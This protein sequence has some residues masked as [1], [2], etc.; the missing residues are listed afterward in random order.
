MTLQELRYLVALADHGHFARAAAACHVGQPTLSTGLRK[1]EQS[2]G[3]ELLDRSQRRVRPTPAGERVIA[4]ARVVLE[5]AERL[6]ALAGEEAADP[7]AGPLRLGVIPTLGPYL[8]PHLLPRVR[9]R[10][11]RL[12]LL[13][14]EEPTAALL[15]RLRDGRLD[16][17]LAALPVPGEGLAGETLFAERFVVA[18]P[19][20]HPLAERT[21][22]RVEDLDPTGV[23]LLEE[24]HC[25]RDQALELCRHAHAARSEEVRATS[26]ETLR[27]MV[28][29]GIG[30]T[31]LPQL[32]VTGA[33]P[34]AGLV[35]YRRFAA[36]EPRRI[37]GLIWRRRYPRAGLLQAFA[38]LVRDHLPAGVEAL[39]GDT[40]G[41]HLAGAPSG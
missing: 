28:A 2:L 10:F 36:P 7:E 24:G 11:P 33:D 37:V 32:A 18:L 21:R 29:A 15:G 25:L 35:R 17:L 23:L 26:L 4:Q 31:L 5:E 38:A 6:R 9:E 13:L 22:V 19:A 20:G 3:V 16:A 12:R 40:I 41:S 30:C 27:Q 8:L 14:R 34:G 1:L 39:P